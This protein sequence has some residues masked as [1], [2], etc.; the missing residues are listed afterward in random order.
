MDTLGA[1]IQAALIP[2][3]N[4]LSMSTEI[5]SLNLETSSLDEP[6][7]FMAS[8]DEGSSSCKSTS[9]GASSGSI[10]NSKAESGG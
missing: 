4:V 3:K 5:I 8:E 1:Q 7:Q 9:S 2:S 6:S 10:V